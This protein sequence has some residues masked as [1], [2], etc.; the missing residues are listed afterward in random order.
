MSKKV[1]ISSKQNTQ[2]S[3]NNWAAAIRL[4]AYLKD[5]K[6]LL[7]V[8]VILL[9][10]S[11]GAAITTSYLLRPIIN[12]YIIPK[13]IP[14]LLKMTFI[15][16]GVYVIGAVS[17][18]M[19][20]RL[21]INIGQ[22]AVSKLRDDLFA[23][24]QAL[25]LKY[26]DKES[27]GDVMSRFTN[28]V[29][30][31]STF[32][33]TSITQFITSSLTLIGVFV[34]MVYISPLLTLFTLGMVALMLWT[35]S[36]IIK[37]SRTY[38]R[39]QQKT[40][41]ALNGYAEEMISGQKT[42]KVFGREQATA[43]EFSALNEELRDKSGKAQLYSG[44][45]MPVMQN[46]NTIN[47]AITAAIG[48]AFAILRGLDIG[49]LAAFLQ[50]SRQ[51]GRPVN[52][53][54]SQYNSM[55]A[56]LAGAERI[57]QVMDEVTE[58]KE[59]KNIIE[60]IDL[61]AIKGEVL[62]ENVFF[63]YEPP[64]TILKDISLHASPGKH[65]ALVGTTGAGKTTIMN[66]LPRFYD[67]QSGRITIDGMDIRDIERNSLRSMLAI[68]LQDTHM[69]SGTIM[70]NIRYG[71]LE[72]TDEEVIATAKLTG[73][74]AFIMRLPDA[75][76]TALTNDGSSLSQG[77]RQ[78]I[79]ITRAAIAQSPV[80]ILDEATSSIDTRTEQIIQKGINQLLEGRTSFVIAHRLST[81][82]NADEI[83]V[84]DQGM[85]VERGSHREL[86]Q[87]K[88]QYYELYKAQFN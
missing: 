13:D 5:Q 52:E 10:L 31:I 16:M 43:E 32:L 77:E 20:N 34:M 30:T 19:Q 41:G 38:F 59:D 2:E 47:F 35:A 53:I 74:D 71:R 4:W 84:L 27:H 87:Q 88:G 64:K 78:L 24:L 69:F 70:D 3:K 9:L 23:K 8:V 49:G 46:L 57:F 42:I 72:A 14:G 83:L 62:L 79:N 39:S 29:D 18:V 15:L 22:N 28:D 55:Q 86:I 45:M 11:S 73:A 82:E 40:I 33:N 56:A 63:A 66:L 21:M 80:L 6:G 67:I 25:P 7:F 1:N 36:F 61:S 75:Y 37:K 17:G 48:G 58:E 12:D 68:V 50:Y 44:M 60:N 76:Q 54:S 51:F 81:L 26:F 65:I 85:I